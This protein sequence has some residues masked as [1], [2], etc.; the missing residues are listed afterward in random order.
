MSENPNHDHAHMPICTAIQKRIFRL[1]VWVWKTSLNT[2]MIG[3][4]RVE[5]KNLRQYIDQK[6]L[7]YVLWF[8]H[9][10]HIKRWIRHTIWMRNLRG[11]RKGIR[12]HLVYTSRSDAVSP[13]RPSTNA[14]RRPFPTRS[15]TPWIPLVAQVFSR[16]IIFSFFDSLTQIPSF[17]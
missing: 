11:C 12:R 2:W 8:G 17:N 4:W 1:C 10:T 9:E 3:D 16:V 15:E 7:V 6:K 5:M 14:G 13:K